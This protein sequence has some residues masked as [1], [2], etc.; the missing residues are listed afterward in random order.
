MAITYLGHARIASTTSITVPAACD[1]IL[2]FSWYVSG[3][4]TA[5]IGGV[6]M[7]KFSTTYTSWFKLKNP[8]V[9]VQTAAI[10]PTTTRQREY[11]FFKGVDDVGQ[12]NE[13]YAS[14]FKGWKTAA[15]T[16][17]NLKSFVIVGNQLGDSGLSVSDVGFTRTNVY[18][19]DGTQEGYGHNLTQLN[20]STASY[21]SYSTSIHAVIC[22]L[23]A[24]APSGVTGVFLSDYGVM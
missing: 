14:S 12:F 15:I 10:A 4:D 19:T 3:V 9:G 2:M 16:A 7:S 20:L 24:A 11:Y 18:A 21:A 22:E 5:T 13:V 6:S 1:F 8:P 23:L 17:K